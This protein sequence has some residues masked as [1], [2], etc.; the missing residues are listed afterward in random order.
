MGR[1]TRYPARI[2]LLPV[3]R[4][5]VCATGIAFVLPGAVDAHPTHALE[6][7]EYPVVAGFENFYIQEDSEDYLAQGGEL[8]LNELN[9]VAC[10]RPKDKSLRARLPGKSGPLL[11]SVGERLEPADLRL[12]ARNPRFVKRGT[13]MPSLFGGPDRDL[14]AIEALTHFLASRK[15]LKREPLPAG[16]VERGKEIYHEVGCVACHDV[17]QGY[18]P[19]S[20]P[21]GTEPELPGFPSVPLAMAYL[22]DEAALAAFLQDPLAVRPAGRMPDMKLNAQEAADVAKYLQA[23]WPAEEE[24]EPEFVLDPALAAEGEKVFARKNCVACHDAGTDKS[25]AGAVPATTKHLEALD[26]AAERSCLSERPLAGGI[27]FYYLDYIQREAITLA[28]RKLKK[29]AGRM[30][31]APGERVDRVMTALNCY[32][33]HARDG[34][35]G[36]ELARAAYFGVT[37]SAAISLGDFGNIPPSLTHVGRKLT[38]SW[39]EKILFGEGGEVRPHM[40]VR[41]PAFGEANVSALTAGFAAADVREPAMEMDV[42][43]LQRHQRGHYGRDLL[44]ADGLGCITCHGLKDAK[45]LGAPA[46]NLTHTVNR[47]QPGFFKELLLDPQGV[48]PGTLMP[49]LFLGR[50]KAEEEVEQI[51]TYLKEIDQRRLP[52]GLLKTEDFELVPDQ[53]PIVFRTFLEGAGM[54]AVTTGYPAG[55][56]VAFD[57]LEIRWAIAWRGRFLDAMSTWDERKAT[58]ARPLGDEVNEFPLWMPLAR[59]ETAETAW[60]EGTGAEAGYEFGGFRLDAGGVPTFLYSFDGLQVEDTLSPSADGEKLRRTVRLR[61]EG[62]DIYF[63]GLGKKAVPRVVM[64]KKGEAV[65]EEEVKW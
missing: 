44:G 12:M 14:D 18:V 8:L 22:Y 36:A 34:K 35:G 19:K 4:I 6:S 57:S 52:E 55:V 11:H 63:R 13:T 45:A 26:P 21:P 41:M 39:M 50:K 30:T 54:Q 15:G 37:D 47:L 43:G 28:L 17:E 29:P 56:H 25:G 60:P 7:I 5:L 42:S 10:H 51:W 53:E 3:A 48:L 31:L 2:F 61:G 32:A 33:C 58:P 1:S 49:P 16:D 62:S 65:I 64:F 9:C 59:L 20:F 23:G 27:P 38:R 46:I 24:T 40:T